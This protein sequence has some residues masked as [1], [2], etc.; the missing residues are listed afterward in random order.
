M[1]E[2]KAE[3]KATN[4]TEI[5]GGDANS[6]KG[7]AELKPSETKQPENKE[8]EVKLKMIMTLLEDLKEHNPKAYQE[9]IKI[10]KNQSQNKDVYNN[11][12]AKQILHNTN[13]QNDFE[14][15]I[16]NNYPNNNFSFNNLLSTNQLLESGFSSIEKLLPENK[17]E[18]FNK[19]LSSIINNPDHLTTLGKAT[20]H[21]KWGAIYAQMGL[22]E[23]AGKKFAKALK[24]VNEI[25]EIREALL[26]TAEVNKSE[27]TK[28]EN[29]LRGEDGVS[30][31]PESPQDLNPEINP[32]NTRSKGWRAL[33][34]LQSEGKKEG[35]LSFV[36]KL[37]KTM[38]QGKSGG[39]E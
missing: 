16:N 4:T 29:A 18:L 33:L 36:E 13:I 8:E 35:R 26:A 22:G 37:K 27:I 23:M 5:E 6:A 34:S 17:K 12:F 21:A 9:I 30:S 38:N 2:S 7:P 24:T 1:S 19:T 31:K 32:E 14:L 10:I 3:T 25:T 15:Q 11:S 39:R 20:D 28:G